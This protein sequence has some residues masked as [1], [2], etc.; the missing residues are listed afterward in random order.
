MSIVSNLEDFRVINMNQIYIVTITEYADR[1][2]RRWDYPEC[3]CFK[4]KESA[5]KYLCKQIDLKIHAILG[6]DHVF[7]TKEVPKSLLKYIEEA[8]DE[9]SGDQI[10]AKIKDEYLDDLDIMMQLHEVLMV[11]ENVEYLFDF[12]LETKTIND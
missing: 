5:E 1:S 12:T 8:T 3:E 2:K 4:T 9:V 10:V 6:D 7:Y 11:G